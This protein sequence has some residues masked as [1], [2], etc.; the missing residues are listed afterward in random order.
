MIT[1]PVEDILFRLTS[2]VYRASIYR[3][4]QYGP[5]TRNFG[6]A[7]AAHADIRPAARLRNRQGDSI[8]VKRGARYRVRV[9]LSRA[10]TP[11]AEGMDRIEVGCFGSQSQSEI[12]PLDAVGAKA[13]GG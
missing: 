11:G 7:G 12:L 9:A 1:K 4:A 2:R 10:E 13:A 3:H 6:N 5:A 8:D